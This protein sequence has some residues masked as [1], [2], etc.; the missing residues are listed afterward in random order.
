MGLLRLKSGQG[1]ADDARVGDEVS[2][3]QVTSAD[4]EAAREDVR[5]GASG[6]LPGILTIVTLS[7]F[8]AGAVVTAVTSS[9]AVVLGALIAAAAGGAVGLP[10]VSGVSFLAKRRGLAIGLE[11][12]VQQRR[13]ELEARRREFE[14][15]LGRGLE[16]VDDEAGAYDTI[17]RAMAQLLPASP[18]ELLLADNSHAHLERM[19]TAMPEGQS[20]PGCPVDT[21]DHCIAARRAQTHVFPDS[22]ALD[23]CPMLRGRS[24]GRCSAACVPVSVMGRTVGLVHTIGAP[25]RPPGEPVVN[26]LQTLANQ[27]G[28]R[29]GML[30]IM[31]ETQLQAATDG[32]TGL[33]NR[34]SLEDQVRMLRGDGVESFAVVMADLDR[35]KDL[36]DTYGHETGDRALRMFG[37]TLRSS[38]R[39]Q[40]LVCRFGGEEFA[41][42]LP[43]CNAASATQILEDFRVEL[44]KALRAAGLPV[45]TASF[46][47]VESEEGESLAGAL[48]RADA[49]LFS[50]KHLGRDCVVTHDRAGASLPLPRRPGGSGA[51]KRRSPRGTPPRVKTPAA[52]AAPPTGGELPGRP[53]PNGTSLNRANGA[54]GA[55]GGSA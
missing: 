21:P 46:G 47:V 33:L 48:R 30:R 11:K 10:F 37:A 2:P 50:A 31:A 15:S 35:F 14:R 38:L 40:D 51:P 43:H 55:N 13:M 53:A 18:V 27:A 9:Y 19:V 26:G 36:N 16:M 12:A 5:R 32:L 3:D 34:R 54:N 52:G 20:E 8:G 28:A 45:Y 17:R 41:V 39:D 42:V 49:A 22:E 23:A 29:L 44:A 24:Q 1:D 7:C 25:G 4:I 6:L